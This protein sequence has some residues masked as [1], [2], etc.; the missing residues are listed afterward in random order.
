MTFKEVSSHIFL[1]VAWLF[2]SL[3]YAAEDRPTSEQKPVPKA[4]AV[5]K[6]ESKDPTKIP[7]ALPVQNNPAIDELAIPK[8]IPIKEDSDEVS[9]PIENKSEETNNI[10]DLSLIHI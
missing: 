1:L 2:S 10:E 8:A 5:P 4:I 6:A 3:V 7:R 9:E